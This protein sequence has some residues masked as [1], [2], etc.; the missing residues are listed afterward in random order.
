MKSLRP[1]VRRC[2]NR[3]LFM[4]EVTTAFNKCLGSLTQNFFE[5]TPFQKLLR[6]HDEDQSVVDG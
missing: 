4:K 3:I 5:P 2:Y 6:G 1:G